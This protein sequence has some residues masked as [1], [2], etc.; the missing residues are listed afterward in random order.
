ME[1]WSKTKRIFAGSLGGVLI[2]SLLVYGIY[3]HNKA[4]KYRETLNYQYDR[5]FYDL[6]DNVNNAE[7]YLL[8][9]VVTGTEEMQTLMLEEAGNAAAQAE[10]CLALLPV[11]QNALSV[12]SDFLVQLK[13]ISSSWDRTLIN[14]GSLTDEQYAMLEEL[15]GYAQDLN[16][17]VHTVWSEFSENGNWDDLQLFEENANLSEPFQDYPELIYDGPFSE[18]MKTTSQVN[19]TGEEITQEEAAS[20]VEKLFEFYTP[21]VEFNGENESQGLEVYSFTV[22]FGEEYAHMARADVTKIGGKLCSM[23]MYRETGEAT[24][25]AEQAV[26]AGESYLNALGY[27]D[28]EPSY[29][30]VQDGYVTANYAYV[31]NGV[32]CFPDMVKVKI[33]MDNGEITGFEAMSYLLNHRDRDIS[34]GKI[35]ISQAQEDLS[36]HINCTDSR[37][38]IIP[39]DY[40]GEEHVYQYECSYNGRNVLIYKDVE[41]G[42]ETEVLILIESD[43]GILTI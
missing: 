38:A 28:M 9:A 7:T 13:D 23:I 16:G 43:N 40:G 25:T 12:V 36:P 32:I 4:D 27:V 6:L 5:A 37:E 1:G 15:Y 3:F 24:L 35:S 30:T 42:A 19:L 14:G 8:K 33:S 18:H 39:N 2:V 21:T 17:A 26:Q 20:Y 22:T 29:Y 31:D 11:D 10:S 34:Q 41:T